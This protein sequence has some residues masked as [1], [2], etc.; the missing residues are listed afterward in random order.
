MFTHAPL[1]P[2]AKLDVESP[3]GP[4]GDTYWEFILRSAAAGIRSR[5]NAGSS[6]CSSGNEPAREQYLRKVVSAAAM[7]R[8]SSDSIY[9]LLDR[10]VDGLV[11]KVKALPGR[12]RR[13]EATELYERIELEREANER[14]PTGIRRVAGMMDTL[15]RFG[16][17]V[18][19]EQL[20]DGGQ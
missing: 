11:A 12:R 3:W 18:D 2:N 10:R 15:N 7:P 14:L 19:E 5:G 1:G 17:D 13:E 9:D 4:N 8:V 16:L 20:Y 6:S